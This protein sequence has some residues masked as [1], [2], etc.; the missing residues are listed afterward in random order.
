[1]SRR[2]KNDLI[3]RTRFSNPLPEPPLPPKLLHI[4][5]TPARYAAPAFTDAMWDSRPWPMLVDSEFG[6][7]LDLAPFAA[8]WRAAEEDPA[9]N[10]AREAPTDPRDAFLFEHIVPSTSSGP[11]SLP[12]VSW[13]RKT[14]YISKEAVNRVSALPPAATESKAL[15]MQPV[16]VSQERQLALVEESFAAVKTPWEGLTHPARPGARAVATMPVLPDDRTWGTKLDV[17]RFAEKPGDREGEGQG[18]DPRLESAIIRPMKTEDEDAWL[19]YYLLAD[20]DAAQ[21]YRA[22]LSAP[23]DGVGPGEEQDQEQDQEKPSEFRWV[24]DYETMRVHQEMQGEA[25]VLL[26]DG[27]VTGRAP[28]AY[29]KNIERRMWLRKRRVRK[30]DTSYASSRWD[31]IHLRHAPM[32]GP[33][34][35]EYR[36]GLAE[37]TDPE[38]WA[39]RALEA[40][41]DAEGEADADAEGEM[42]VDA[43]AEGELDGEGQAGTPLPDGMR[44]EVNGHGGDPFEAL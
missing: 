34:L 1:M 2:S 3:L 18:P 43:D 21:A 30:N 15:A 36:E 23:D 29:Y 7:P 38:Y 8:V 24:R 31:A 39:R 42:E 11:S 13:L 16:D 32:E 4:P 28:G 12:N 5:T 37:V 9:M 27:S 41:L 40:E 17:Y 6:M 33:E 19:A 25:I 22:R 20:D 14:E 10:P 44:V 26:D 35:A